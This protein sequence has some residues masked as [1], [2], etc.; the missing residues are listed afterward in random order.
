MWKKQSAIFVAQMKVFTGA[1]VRGLYS[2]NVSPTELSTNMSRG[3]MKQNSQRPD[4]L[5]NTE[6]HPV[7]VLIA[8]D[9]RDPATILYALGTTVNI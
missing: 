4:D 7:S 3:T 9:L 5:P 6:L 2:F 8:F 1:K